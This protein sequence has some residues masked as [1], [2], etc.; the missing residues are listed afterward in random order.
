MSRNYQKELAWQRKKYRRYQAMLPLNEAE[1]LQRQLDKDKIGFTE[2]VRQKI[3][4][5]RPRCDEV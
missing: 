4:A 2:W 5:D 1:E 3:I